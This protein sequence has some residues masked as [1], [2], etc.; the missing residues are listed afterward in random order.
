V[1]DIFWEFFPADLL[2]NLSLV[3]KYHLGPCAFLHVSKGR[4]LS[5]NILGRCPDDWFQPW[6]KF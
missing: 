2:E 4:R 1:Q 3:R 6:S 5:E